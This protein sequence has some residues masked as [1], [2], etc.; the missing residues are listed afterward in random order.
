MK[1][2]ITEESGKVL[3]AISGELSANECDDLKRDLAPLCE[4]KGLNIEMDLSELEYVCSRGLRVF[5][6][7]AQAQEA[8][9]GSVKVT[10][11]TPVVREVFDLT[12]FTKIFIGPDTKVAVN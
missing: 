12:G 10:A 2:T 6:A 7:L 3:V 1:T 4:R 8:D 9:G 5:L 11:I